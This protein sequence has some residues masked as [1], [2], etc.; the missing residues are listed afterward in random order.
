MRQA[1]FFRYFLGFKPPLRVR[2]QL[3]EAGWRAGPTG[4]RVSGER[5]HLTLCVVGET[6]EPDPFIKRRI[7]S[8]LGEYRLSSAPIPLGRVTGNSVGAFVR[9]IGRQRPIQ[10]LY[11]DLTGALAARDI[12]PWYRKAGLRPHV[13]LAHGACEFAPFD[14]SVEWIPDELL[15]IESE[16]GLSQ[17]NVLRRW[18]LLAPAQGI[19]PFDEWS[20]S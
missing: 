13:T 4:K 20:G 3:V 18:S 17:H 6:P 12:A 19:L 11:R 10:T 2:E 15:L 1:I 7:E 16:F 14:I 8:A 9:T 5:V